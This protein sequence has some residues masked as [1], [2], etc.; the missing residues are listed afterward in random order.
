[1]IGE[2]ADNT[3]RGVEFKKAKAIDDVVIIT[4][5]LTAEKVMLRQ[6]CRY[7]H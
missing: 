1:V 2:L 6:N 3:W 5:A 4:Q 7:M